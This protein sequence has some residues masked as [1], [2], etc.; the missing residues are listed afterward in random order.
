MGG[1]QEVLFTST[2]PTH[3]KK[4]GVLVGMP[5]PANCMQQI[6]TDALPVFLPGPRL[7]TRPVCVAGSALYTICYYCRYC[8]LLLPLALPI[9]VVAIWAS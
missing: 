7:R 6:G 2:M 9:A 5:P 4:N 1:N 3:T 8:R